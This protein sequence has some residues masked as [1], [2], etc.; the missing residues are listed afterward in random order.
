MSKYCRQTAT[1]EVIPKRNFSG[2]II[3]LKVIFGVSLMS[4]ILDQQ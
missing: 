2:K 3:H 1:A 4:N